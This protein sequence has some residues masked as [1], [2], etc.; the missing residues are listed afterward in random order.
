[1]LILAFPDLHWCFVH[2][3][4]DKASQPESQT[5][6]SSRRLSQENLELLKAL[7]G[8]ESL[9]SERPPYSN[10]FDGSGVRH[11]IRESIED[12]SLKPVCRTKL[13]IAVDDERQYSHFSGLV[14][15]R[16]G[17]RCF[18]I[19]SF[20]LAKFLL[21]SG[22][23]NE[24]RVGPIS[25]SIE[26]LNLRFADRFDREPLSDAQVRCREFVALG[27]VESLILLTAANADKAKMHLD[28]RTNDKPGQWHAKPLEGVHVR[29]W[30]FGLLECD[31]S[32]RQLVLGF[33]P[34]P[35]PVVDW[36]AWIRGLRR[37]V[38]RLAAPSCLE[39]ACMTLGPT[40]HAAKPEGTAA[41]TEGDAAETEDDNQHHSAPG[42]MVEVANVLLTRARALIQLSDEQRS[43]LPAIRASV[44]A[45]DARELLRNRTPTTCLTAIELRHEAEL[46]AE[47]HFAGVVLSPAGIRLRIREIHREVD[48]VYASEDRAV[49]EG[50]NRFVTA[51]RHG[52]RELTAFWR[53]DS[54]RRD[55]AL[56][57]IV[58]RLLGALEGQHQLEAEDEFLKEDRRLQ[59]RIRWYHRTE[60]PRS[61]SARDGSLMSSIV[62][63][64]RIVGKILA[65]G[66]FICMRYLNWLLQG[67]LR[68]V[69]ASSLWLAVFSW[70]LSK[71][72]SPDDLA[73]GAG[74]GVAEVH[75][76]Q[77]SFFTFT[78]IGQPN[79]TGADWSHVGW[80]ISVAALMLIGL[81]HIGILISQVYAFASRR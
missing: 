68:L 58:S 36:P 59:N 33:E 17:Y 18:A 66:E 72:Q 45:L 71:S 29:D 5:E 47:F 55:L 7:H 67:V 13:C 9:S 54:K 1:M 14:G 4:P 49:K 62:A 65:F 10:L 46:H 2:I 24:S 32:E 74:G 27:N 20:A 21:G 16:H 63:G 28:G 8:L 30:G 35:Y 61:P 31:G 50:G 38:P 34:R 81:L 15:Y 19:D 3:T 26:D 37:I 44:L 6:V 70:I 60:R 64:E 75:A 39:R 22:K 12:E 40:G 73:S 25:L 56:G 57:G 42:R 53:G 80:F 52:C 11:M 23:E 69:L 43:P 51:I 76:L 79:V 77:Y 41:K 78:G 48:A